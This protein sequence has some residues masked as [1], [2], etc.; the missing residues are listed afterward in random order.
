MN[1]CARPTAISRASRS[2][3]RH[4]LPPRRRRSTAQSRSKG[5]RPKDRCGPGFAKAKFKAGTSVSNLFSLTD[6]PGTPFVYRSALTAH[7][8]RYY[9]R[10]TPFAM[11]EDELW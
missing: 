7:A 1:G 2:N 8:R 5:R 3:S 6:S 9:T 11:I 4:Y 10:A